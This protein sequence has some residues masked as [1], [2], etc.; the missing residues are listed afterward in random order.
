MNANITVS[1]SGGFDFIK[2]AIGTLKN[3]KVYIGIPEAETTRKSKAV[4]NAGLLFIHTNGSPLRHIPARPVI[5]PSIEA[6][7]EV[8]EEGLHEA[9]SLIL[10]GQKSE[11]EI[12][13]KKVGTL[14]ATGAKRWFTDSRNGWRQNAPSTIRRKLAKLTGQ[15]LRKALKVLNSIDENM[16][17]YGTSELDSINTP[18]I[19]TGEMRRSISHVEEI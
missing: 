5:E 6:N 15:R 17:L 16:P 12:T 8:L 9:A 19:D 1:E 3:A 13:L 11:A 4:T 14:G 10:D 2:E 18:L 7:H